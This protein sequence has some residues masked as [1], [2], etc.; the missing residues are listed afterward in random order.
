MTITRSV[1]PVTLRRSLGNY[2]SMA[3]VLEVLK[4]GGCK[5]PSRACF[6]ADTYMESDT[7]GETARTDIAVVWAEGE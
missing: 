3:E 7:F 5:D 1:R 4:E 6:E 2:F